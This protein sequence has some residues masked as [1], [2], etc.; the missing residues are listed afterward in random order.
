[1]S[2]MQKAIRRGE[3]DLALRAA[4]TLLRDAPDRLW[5]RVACIAFEDI[6][7]ADLDAVFLVTS[8]LAGKTFRARLGGEWPV[9]SFIVSRMVQAPKCRGADDLLLTAEQHPGLQ[10]QRRELAHATTPDLIA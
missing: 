5:R 10:Q 3:E 6:G 8:A 1:M 9:A 7:V 4:A 2:L